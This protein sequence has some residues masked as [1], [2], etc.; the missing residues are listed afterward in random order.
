MSRPKR[1]RE[2]LEPIFPRLPGGG[3]LSPERVAAHQ[4]ARL[5]GAMVEAVRRSGYAQVTIRELVGLAGVSKSAF[6]RHF[7]SKQDCFLATLD[8]IAAQGARRV[9][10]AYREGEGLGGS[11][12]A[13]LGAF[14]E[15]VAEEPAAAS[16]ALVDSLHLG[17]AGVAHREAA[18]ARF[19]VLVLRSFA[20]AGTPLGSLE[21]RAIVGGWRQVAYHALRDGE[22]GRFAAG[23]EDLVSWALSYRSAGEITVP[24][25]P[26]RPVE[27]EEDGIEEFGWSE[28]PDS[29]A[30][31]RALDRRGRILRAVA[32]LAAEEGP[33]AVTIPA[34]SAR[35]GT[36]NEAWYESFSSKDEALGAAF[37]A[38]GARALAASVAAF[39]AE[40]DWERGVAAGV[41]ALLRHVADEPI[42][43]RL[44]FFA[45]PAS[46]P[47]G[48]ER[49]DVAVDAF[50]A[51]LRPGAF[52]ADRPELP[53]ITRD[54]IA[55][56]VWTAV[57]YELARGRAGRLPALAPGFA[58]LALAPF[59]G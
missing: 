21:A 42:F 46:G 12:L 18:A 28:P 17:A 38:L 19:E 11:L 4:R 16:L 29:A 9:E 23:V 48:L 57:Q 40:D 22:P 41:A 24:S 2:A 51:Y 45:M 54:A 1:R 52:G 14:A 13:G 47:A 8:E 32:Q 59:R 15:I 56:G 37:E 34:V 44:A 43:A 3:A 27:G 26:R 31:R 10:E 50:T 58:A 39:E 33:E 30:A 35:A 25:P 53:A 36:S 49:S 5:M 7:D 6:Y 20:A 55:G